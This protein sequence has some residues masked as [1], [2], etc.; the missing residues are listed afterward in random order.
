MKEL[1]GINVIHKAFGIGTV[2]EILDGK[3]TIEFE[4][5]EKQFVF[6]DVFEKF[7]KVEDDS[8]QNKLLKLIEEKKAAE[9]AEKEKII[10]EQEEKRKQELK[11]KAERK[12]TRVE[13]TKDILSKGDYFHT[14]ADALNACFGYQYEHYQPGFKVIDDKYSAWFPTVARRVGT[15]YTS[16]DNSYGWVNILSENDTVITEKNEDSAKNT[17]RDPK[18]EL[19]R[20]VFAKYDEGYT[21]VG[22]Y[23]PESTPMPWETGYRYK[24]V[25]TKVDLKKM[26]VL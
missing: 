5:C 24:L 25:G 23:R 10:A 6:P 1:V 22:V 3:I 16:T 8:L 14:H 4:Q 21:F 18:F 19:D 9:Q 15:S 7:L 17:V 2:K 20:F 13:P 11:Q 26:L 12:N